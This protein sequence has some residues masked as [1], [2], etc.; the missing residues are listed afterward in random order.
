MATADPVLVASRILNASRVA[1]AADDSNKADWDTGDEFIIAVQLDEQKG[2]WTA[3]YKLQW[4]VSGGSYA[5]LSDITAIAYGTGTDLANGNAVVIGEKACTNTPSGSWA[6]GWEV[7]GTGTASSLELLDEEYSELHIALDPA[8]ATAE[9]TYEFR[10]YDV[11]NGAVVGECDATIT[12]ASG[13]QTYYQSADGVGTYSGEVTK[14]T[15]DSHA[16]IYAA[17]GAL[18]GKALKATAGTFEA[19]GVLVGKALK[20]TAGVFTATGIVVG[21]AKKALSGTLEATG[22]VTKKVKASVAGVI[23]FSGTLSGTKVA[24]QAAAGVFE[25]SG[26]LVSKALKSLAGIAIYSGELAKKTSQSLVGTFA[27]VG[28]VT[29]NVANTVSGTFISTGAVSTSFTSGGVSI[30]TGGGDRLYLQRLRDRY[31]LSEEDD[32]IL[33]TVLADLL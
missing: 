1:Q 7:E 18:I 24:Y 23:T 27:A 22:T 14:K 8:A 33:V 3:V 21:K 5:D 10:L 25:A 11:T 16:G 17:T 19:S 20:A 4:Q 12:M 26:V 2:P 28:D 31:I 15:K 13:A 9:A 30:P 6:D 29:K 32:E